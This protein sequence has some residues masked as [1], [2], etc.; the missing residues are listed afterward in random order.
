MAISNVLS[1]YKTYFLQQYCIN[2]HAKPINT[3][4]IIPFNIQLIFINTCKKHLFLS[5]GFR[6]EEAC[7][8]NEERWKRTD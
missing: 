6:G 7:F 3:F 1:N 5:R 4:S 8:D 2:E